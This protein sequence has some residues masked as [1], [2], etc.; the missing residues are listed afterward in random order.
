MIRCCCDHSLFCRPCASVHDIRV[1]VSISSFIRQ[2]VHLSATALALHSTVKP[3]LSGHSKIDK[4]KVLKT[5]DS[6]MQVK[7]IAECSLGAFC[8]TFDLH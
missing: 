6:L 1:Q 3:V 8:N 7:C 4:T 5:D 2:F